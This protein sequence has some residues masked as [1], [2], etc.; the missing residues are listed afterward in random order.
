MLLASRHIPGRL[1]TRQRVLIALT[2]ASLAVLWQGTA[3]AQ[4]PPP[5]PPAP[6]AT[7]APTA[8]PVTITGAVEANYTINA[9]RPFNGSN[10]YLYNT[11]EGQF[12]LNLADLHVAKAATP[13]SRFGFLIR[14]IAGEVARRNFA[15]GDVNIGDGSTVR[16]LEGY[17]TFLV[18]F[19]GRD[20]KV[21]AGQFVTH[22]GYETIEVGTNNFFSR[23]WL[24][25][26]PSPFYDA[27]VRAALPVNDKFTFTGYIYNRYNG[28][29][30]PGNRDLAP[31]FQAT[32]TPTPSASYTL[33]GLTSRENLDYTGSSNLNGSYPVLNRQQSVLDFIYTKQVT[34]AFKFVG[35]GLY[36]FGKDYNNKNYDEGGGAGYLIYT[37][38]N[39]NTLAFRGEYVSTLPQLSATP[40]AS[41]PALSSGTV[42]YELHS[43]LFTGLRTLLEYRYD[44]SGVRFFPGKNANDSLKKSQS[45]FTIG[46]IYSF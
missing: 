10:T 7:P 45:T 41:N 27:G 36:R 2:G 31:G 26:Y 40:G 12:S 17:G 11:N 35:E 16:L 38:K 5:T 43:G 44:Q 37:L 18:P 23:N 20:L 21:D 9:N 46:E 42:S 34:P 33:N 1:I 22:V 29:Y 32:Y 8:P 28:V 6:P 4:T 19:K 3:H 24:F 39:G 13:T 15:P 14:P 25:Q 30:D